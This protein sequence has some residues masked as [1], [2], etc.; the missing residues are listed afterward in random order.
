MK[1]ILICGKA[2]SGKNQLAD[3]LK[4]CL[5]VDKKGA[6]FDRTL[7]RG[8]AQ[9]VKERAERQFNW[10]GEKDAKGRQLLID[11]TNKGY[12]IDTYFWEKEL[13]TEA[14]M[15]KAFTNKNCE[16]LIVPDWRYAQTLDYFNVVAEEVIT[17][18]I[19]R[20]NLPKGTH[21]NHI[22]ENA[23]DLFDVQY[24]VDNNRDLNNLK[25]IAKR[26]AQEF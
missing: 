12:N 25:N 16:Y 10:N 11:V 22:S 3:Y 20:P 7:I 4:E 5:D 13:F 1:V 21:E 2:R 9:S 18:R 19:T 23:L 17:I 6:Y 8:N 15:Y 24:E 26:I 14:I